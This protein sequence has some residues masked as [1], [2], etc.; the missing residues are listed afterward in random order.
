MSM[1]CCELM[2]DVSRLLLFEVEDDEEREREDNG[3]YCVMLRK[4]MST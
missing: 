2:R 4:V 3:G 1:C